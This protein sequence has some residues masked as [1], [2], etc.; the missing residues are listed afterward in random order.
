GVDDG[1]DAGILEFLRELDVAEL[2]HL[3]P[4][5]DG[6][7]AVLGIDA[8]GD[9]PGPASCGAADEIGVP[10]GHRAEDDAAHA[11]VEPCL[12]ARLVADAAAEL[13]RQAHRAKNTLD[14]FGVAGS[15]REGAVE[16]DDM[17][18]A[19]ALRG[20]FLRLRGG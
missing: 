12:D 2:R 18:P 17:Q 19:K 3:R 8:N 4:A 1:G 13:H 6:D 9:A 20:E 5:L 15:A 14:R 16:V 7:A 11:L 10:R